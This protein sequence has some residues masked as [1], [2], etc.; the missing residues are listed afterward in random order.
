MLLLLG[1]LLCFFGVAL[2]LL[3]PALWEREIHHQY[4][5]PRAV[6]CPETHQQVGVVIDAAHA[7]STGLSGTPKFR[8]ADCTRWPARIHCGQECLPEALQNEPYTKGEV[9]LPK[10]SRQIFHLPVL[11]AAFGAWY[12]GML[13]HSHYLFRERW[14]AALGLTT[15]DWKQLVSWYSPHLLSI[16]A[17]LLFAYGVA[18]LRTWLP[19][20]G[21][22]QGILSSTLLWAALALATLPSVYGL[23]RDLL[24]IEA[25]YTLVATIAVGA[26]IGSLSGKLVLSDQ[27]AK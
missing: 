4:S 26:I 10:T 9:H 19:G 17:C 18:W 20:K 7:A 27:E 15:A 13:W 8:L 6:T 16:A 24:V 2:I 21:L 11:L 14:M 3:L 22:W 23:S 5:A 12:V 25:G 1:L